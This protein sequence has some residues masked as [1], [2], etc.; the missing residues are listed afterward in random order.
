MSVSWGSSP[1]D[2]LLAWFWAAGFNLNTTIR[3]NTADIT[4]AQWVWSGHVRANITSNSWGIGGLYWGGFWGTDWISDLLSM[5]NLGGNSTYVR[6]ITDIWSAGV[7]DGPNTGQNLGDVNYSSPFI[8]FTNGLTNNTLYI[9]SNNPYVGVGL[10]V[11]IPASAGY[12]VVA[13]YYNGANWVPVTVTT[14][15]NLTEKGITWL[16]FTTPADWKLTN[17]TQNGQQLYWIQLIE[18][19]TNNPQTSNLQ[20]SNILFEYKNPYEGYPGMLMVVAAGNDN[21]YQ[22]TASPF[23]TL[24]LKV[25]A[26]SSSD[27]FANLYGSDW[28]T[29]SDQM[30]YFSSAGPKAN[31]VTGVDIVA[32]GYYVYSGTPLYHSVID[33]SHGQGDITSYGGNGLNAYIIWA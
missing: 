20:I 28:G 7:L 8:P 23:G 13:K 11:S 26:S 15:L 9:G 3:A 10:N 5:P 33:N 24:T 1:Q 2:E 30:A 4:G 31:G 22:S 27:A 17:I 29:T 25:G 6:K 19:P 32:P 16:K 21:Y 12:V 14:N 18:S